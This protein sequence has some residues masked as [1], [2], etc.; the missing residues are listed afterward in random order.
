MVFL[1][2]H[3]KIFLLIV[4]LS[5]IMFLSGCDLIYRLVHK[6]G[7]EEKDLIGDS[8]PFESNPKVLEIQKLLQLYGYRAGTPDGGL[9]PFTRQAIEKFQ[10]DSDLTPT[11]FV[12]KQTWAKLTMFGESGLVVNGEIDVKVVQSALKSAGFN[13]GKIDG[14][15]GPQTDKAIKAFQ[16]AMGLEPDGRIGFRT[17]RELYDFLSP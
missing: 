1:R 7:A 8:I 12:D 2:V 6:E 3:K 9:G 4:G 13:P 10:E 15:G 5:I 14:K 16:K 11:G 17:L